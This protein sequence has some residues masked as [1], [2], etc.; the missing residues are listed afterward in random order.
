MSNLKT[1]WQE[2][3]RAMAIVAGVLIALTIA[4]IVALWIAGFVFFALARHNPFLAGGFGY[5]DALLDWK[6]GLLPGYGKRLAIAGV[7]GGIVP[8]VGPLVLVQIVRAQSEVRELHGSARFA[9][10]QEIRKAKLL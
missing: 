5:L 9:N 6:H 2:G 3:G 8:F 7:I 1:F 4:S 10:E